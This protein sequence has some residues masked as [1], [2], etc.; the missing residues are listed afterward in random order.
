MAVMQAYILED[1]A[2]AGAAALFVGVGEQFVTA[3][4][5]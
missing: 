3:T 2:V 1:E 5:K 4:G